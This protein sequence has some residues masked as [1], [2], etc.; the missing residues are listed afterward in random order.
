MRNHPEGIVTIGDGLAR[1]A[2]AVRRCSRDTVSSAW[3]R[4][5]PVPTQH[6]SGNVSTMAH[7]SGREDGLFT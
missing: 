1:P 4:G 5:L 3:R 6:P 7:L 2:M